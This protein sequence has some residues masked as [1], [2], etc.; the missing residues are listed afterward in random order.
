MTIRGA[1]FGWFLV[2]LGY[3]LVGALL[4]QKCTVSDPIPVAARI[5]YHITDPRFIAPPQYRAWVI[6][7]AAEFGV[8]LDVAIRLA[9]EESRW[10]PTLISANRNGSWDHG[11]YQLNSRYHRVQTVEGNIRAGL[12]YWAW[13]WRQTGTIRGATIAY[14]TG[15]NGMKHARGR[16]LIEAANVAGGGM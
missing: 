4:L 16:T 11:L 6:Q 14:Q 12:E 9:Y 1:V 8:P 15:V 5:E 3:T 10:R 7:Y 13:C 2:V